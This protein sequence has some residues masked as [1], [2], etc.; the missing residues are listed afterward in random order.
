MLINLCYSILVKLIYPHLFNSGDKPDRPAYSGHPKR[1]HLQV[2]EGFG[3]RPHP[4]AESKEGWGRTWRK[5]E[6]KRQQPYK[7]SITGAQHTTTLTQWSTAHNEVLYWR[8]GVCT[9]HMNTSI[10]ACFQHNGCS[11]NRSPV[12][13]FTITYIFFSKMDA[14]P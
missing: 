5:P 12:S 13:S 6:W 10:S 7:T 9:S 4:W 8:N 2:A 3:Q 1:W 14:F 11:P